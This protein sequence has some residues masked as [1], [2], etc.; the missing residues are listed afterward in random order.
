MTRQVRDTAILAKIETTYGTDAVPT[1]GANAILVSNFSVNPLQ[2][3]NIDRALLRAYFGGSEQLIGTAYKEISFD[4]ELTGSGTAGTAPAWGPLLRACAMAETVTASTR[5]DYTPITNAQ[6]SISIYCYDSGVLHKLVGTR[7]SFDMGAKVGDIPKLSFKF[8]GL[9]AGDSV[10]SNPALTLTGWKTPQVVTPAFTPSF[11]IG[12]TVAATG[13]PAISGGASYTSA[14]LELASGLATTY[15]GLLGLESV[16]VTARAVSGKLMLDLSP[17]QEV[18]FMGSVKLNTLQAVSMLH[19]TVVGQKVL[20]HL[21]TAQF[22]NPSKTE[23]NGRRL[24]GYDLRAVPTP[25]GSGNDEL[26][27]TTSF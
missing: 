1:G 26:R 20:L 23:L 10:S 3:N 18:A 21:P 4:V 15:T 24:I 7:G 11:I 27:I 16:D 25:G 12:G 5:V 2:A 13:A 9:D 22:I 19:G 17:T 14:G 8:L 6:E